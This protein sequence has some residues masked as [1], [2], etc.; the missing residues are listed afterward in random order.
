M[1]I[2]PNLSTTKGKMMFWN[3]NLSTVENSIAYIVHF[4]NAFIKFFYFNT[5]MKILNKLF[6]L[7]PFKHS[8]QVLSNAYFNSLP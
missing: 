6:L 5:E 8:C 4:S 2:L 3:Q 1:R 7:D